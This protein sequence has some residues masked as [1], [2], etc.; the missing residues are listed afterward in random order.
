[1]AGIGF[2]LRRM[3]DQRQ[4][5][6]AKVRAYACAGLISSGPWLMTI[7]TL[8]LL[9]VAGPA[10]RGEGDIRL[11]RALVTYAFAFSLILVGAGQMSITRRIADLLYSKRYENVLPAFAA[12]FLVVAAVHVVIGAGFC[13]LAG[14]PPA[15]SFLAVSLFAIIGTTWISLI[16]LSV[17]RQYDQVLRAYVYGT[18]VSVGAM[19]LM[20]FGNATVSTLAAYASGQALTLVLL[21]RTI[22]RGM[23]AGGGRDFSVFTSLRAF[24]QLVGVGLLYNAAI[25]V[26][27]MVFWFRDGVGPHPMVRYHPLYDTC[28]FLAY[29]TVVPALAVNLIRLETSFYEHY[30]AYYG[31]ILGNTPLSVIEDKRSRMFENLQESTIRLLRVQGF[32]TVA[33]IVFAP[34]LMNLLELPAAATRLFRLT[35]IGAF[36]HVMLLL[37]ILMQLYFDLRKQALGTSACFLVL[38]LGLAWW[39]VDRGVLSYGIG[40]AVASFLSLLLGYSLLHRS[41]ERLDYLTFTSQPIGGDDDLPQKGEPEAQAQDWVRAPVE[42]GQ[43]EEEAAPAAGEMAPPDEPKPQIR[44]EPAA[45]ATNAPD[46][47]APATTATETA[48]PAPLPATS[49][50]EATATEVGARRTSVEAVAREVVLPDPETDDTAVTRTEVG[51]AGDE[52]TDTGMGPPLV[53]PPAPAP[54]VLGEEGPGEPG[55]DTKTITDV[56]D[57]LSRRKP[58]QP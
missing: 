2:E 41:L 9:T 52:T 44:L 13:V 7:L 56:P 24:P 27:K 5:F 1:M 47:P 26:D 57:R 36:F 51:F 20:G 38:N 12:S 32:I 55:P 17:A 3:I 21:V 31:S 43:P 4:G 6:L 22:L 25:W 39:S 14:F 45:G 58:P 48:A 35:C 46:T 40:Y 16:W 10:F 29:L 54:P 15:L 33:L 53:A 50:P 37:T 42:S 28:S 30:R 34:P 8:T 23:E 19:A 11:F 49:D 18:V